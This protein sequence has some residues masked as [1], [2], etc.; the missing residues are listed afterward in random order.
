M[1]LFINIF[2][3]HSLKIITFIQLKIWAWLKYEQKAIFNKLKCMRLK[4]IGL[5]D[6]KAGYCLFKTHLVH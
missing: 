1:E 5:S 2:K 6:D 4:Q 3:M